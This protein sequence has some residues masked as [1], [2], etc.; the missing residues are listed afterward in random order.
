MNGTMS[1]QLA[2][3]YKEKAAWVGGDLVASMSMGLYNHPL[4]VYR[5]LVQNSADAYQLSGLPP[6]QRPVEISVD[7]A[8]RRVKIRDYGTGLSAS[9]MESNLLAIG[10]SSK[11]GKELRGFRGIG[12]LAALGYC[13]KVVFRSRK[14][15]ARKVH[16]LEWDSVVLHQLIAAKEN[17]TIEDVF[18]KMS[19]ES[20]LEKG[21]DWPDRF[22]ECE[23]VGV[24]AIRNDVLLNSD[25]ISSY[26]SEV[27]PVGFDDRFSFAPQIY[28][29]LGDYLPF[30]VDIYI[31]GNDRPLK[32]P[33][34]D[35]I[36]SADGKSIFTEINNV[37]AI[38]EIDEALQG[39]SLSIARGW[40]LHH[41]YFGALP[42]GARVRGLRI[43][44]GN[45][46]VGDERVLDHLFK[47]TRFNSWCIGEIHVCSPDIRP[48][49]R[50][51]NLESSPVLEDFEHSLRILALNLQT[52]CR[53][54]S[55]L[56]NKKKK[57]SHV[58]LAL[59]TE[60]YKG[61]LSTLGISSSLPQKVTISTRVNEET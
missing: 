4:E 8:G 28:A 36:L 38:G 3:G 26:L 10:N 53:N 12:R 23:L 32:K 57:T 22:F 56:R 19:T 9:E 29:T 24:R 40:I 42:K 18:R 16:Q 34:A 27:G 52:M 1:G 60:A 50:R 14:S 20:E 48:N 47:E 21:Q 33:H 39:S 55:S 6:G 15:G 35:T 45:I 58:S 5:E 17:Y 59:S 54:I 2:P 41:D 37:S 51:D 13:K 11:R 7:R 31:N 49:T 30:E 43:R 46:Q 44:V 25:A 61:I